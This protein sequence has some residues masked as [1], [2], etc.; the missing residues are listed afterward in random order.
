MKKPKI[1]LTCSEKVDNNNLSLICNHYYIEAIKKT[2]GIPIL[3]DPSYKGLEDE[4]IEMVQGV[5]FTGGGD[6]APHLYGEEPHPET[7]DID[8]ERDEF[9]IKILEKAKEKNIPILG[10]CRG[11]QLIN[12][13]SGGTLYQDLPNHTYNK[14]H[15]VNLKENSFLKDIFKE[16]KIEVNSYHHQAINKVAPNFDV[17]A[18]TDDDIIEAIIIKDKEKFI[19]GVQWHPE[20]MY[21]TFER[22]FKKFIEIVRREK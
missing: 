3:S 8:E 6:I 11:A 12:V 19:L 9:E 10:I 16:D 17:I 15:M 4:L 1:L 22:L 13:A 20:R 7:K 14:N 2:G 21:E 5:V 18:K